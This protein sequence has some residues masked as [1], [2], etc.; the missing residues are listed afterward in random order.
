MLWL[1]L[2]S[3]I[4]VKEG[5]WDV[6]FMQRLAGAEGVC[7]TDIW[8]KRIPSRKDNLCKGPGA[9]ACLASSRSSKL[10]WLQQNGA[11]AAS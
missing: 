5:H 11:G 1:R 9:E 4:V 2:L 10:V 8:G 3:L 7:H 6:T